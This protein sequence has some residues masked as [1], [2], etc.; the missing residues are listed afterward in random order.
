MVADN[1]L[2]YRGDCAGDRRTPCCSFEN[3][4]DDLSHWA[5]VSGV[6][7]NVLKSAELCVGRHLPLRSLEKWT[8]LYSPECR[9][10]CTLE[11]I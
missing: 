1:T 4:L 6:G 10:M 8:G 3:D 11:F 9:H 2:L 7:F 5:A